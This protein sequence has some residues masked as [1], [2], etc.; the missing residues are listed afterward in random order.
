MSLQARV[1]AGLPLAGLPGCY[2]NER[3]NMVQLLEIYHATQEGCI[4]FGNMFNDL[5]KVMGVMPGC[6]LLVEK[7]LYKHEYIH[8]LST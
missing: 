4:F 5:R 1:T 3:Q 8:P 7:V 6:T 2:I